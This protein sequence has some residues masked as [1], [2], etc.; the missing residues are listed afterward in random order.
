MRKNISHGITG[1]YMSS[2]Q[3]DFLRAISDRQGLKILILDV[4]HYSVS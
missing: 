4:I 3:I 1:I 2:Y